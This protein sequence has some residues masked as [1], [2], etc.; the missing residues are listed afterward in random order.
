MKR[1]VPFGFVVALIIGYSRRRHVDESERHRVGSGD[2]FLT[3]RR[4]RT[5]RDARA[6]RAGPADRSNA[7]ARW[8]PALPSIS[9]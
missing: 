5:C 3:R 4:Y 9:S 8:I 7:R 2:M 6:S 1:F